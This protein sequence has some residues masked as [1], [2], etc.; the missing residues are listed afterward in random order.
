M[1]LTGKNLS[2]LSLTNYD[3]VVGKE[4]EDHFMWHDEDICVHTNIHI[5]MRIIYVYIYI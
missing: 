5:Y 2:D 4:K 3:Q 1:Y